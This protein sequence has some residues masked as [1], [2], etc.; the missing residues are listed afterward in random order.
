[1]G[2]RLSYFPSP[3]ITPPVLH[4]PC[5]SSGSALLSLGQSDAS[6]AQVEAFFDSAGF[7]R[8][9]DLPFYIAAFAPCSARGPANYSSAAHP[10]QSCSRLLGARLAAVRGS[11]QRLED[12]RVS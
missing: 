6:S 3:G 5:S 10:L 4:R 11:V 9:F 1:M 2:G 12:A 7:P 8:R